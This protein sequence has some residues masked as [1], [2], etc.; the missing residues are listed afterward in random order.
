VW[1]LG[2]LYLPGFEVRPT[3][4][5]DRIGRGGD[6]IPFVE[7]G[8]PG[9]RFTERLENYNRQ[10][11]PT[12]ELAHVNFG[13]VARVARLDAATVVSLASA[14]A[15]PD[16]VKRRREASASGGQAWTVTWLPVAGAVGYEILVRRTTSPTWE[17]AVPVGRVTR[18]VLPFQLDDGWAG[19]R[20]VG[21]DGHRSLAR[22]AGPV[23]PPV[24]IARPPQ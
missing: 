13:Y 11:L 22:V 16:S 24:P 9:L 4:R 5:L 15:A 2:A 3:W 17:Q 20:A 6:H 18:Y 10:H 19:V 8:W 14:P 1:G 7:S 23:A 12:D 21:A